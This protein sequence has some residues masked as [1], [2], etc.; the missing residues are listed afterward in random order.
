MVVGVARSC[1]LF[2][3]MADCLEP[4]SSDTLLALK[5]LGVGAV[6]RYLETLTA[7]ERDLVFAAGLPI[8]PLT[9]A[10]LGALSATLGSELATSHLSLASAL[11]VPTT[12]HLMSDFEAQSGDAEGYDRALTSA[13]AQA[14]YV[15]LAYIG[16][17]QTL[18]G[19]ELFELPDVHIYWRG[20]SLGIAEPDCGFAIWQ[21]PPLDQ[22]LAGT[23]IDVSLTGADVRGRSPVLWYPD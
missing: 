2:T 21:I 22:V 9:E 7:T 11:G 20:G 10:P 14:G 19:H 6:G 13:L 4:L 8:L 18:T 3:K 15:P 12:V 17:G 23:R 16:A 5:T 1:P